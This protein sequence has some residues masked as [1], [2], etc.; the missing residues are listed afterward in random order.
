MLQKGSEFMI[1]VGKHIHTQK[2]EKSGH[3]CSFPRVFT[4]ASIIEIEW[5]NF[6]NFGSVD[7]SKEQVLPGYRYFSSLHHPI[8]SATL[9]KTASEQCKAYLRELIE[10][11]VFLTLWKQCYSYLMMCLKILIAQQQSPLIGSVSRSV[12]K[13]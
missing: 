5:G 12:V 4:K 3:I 10:L 13:W 7:R 1:S 9:R 6:K 2:Q 8:T 11:M